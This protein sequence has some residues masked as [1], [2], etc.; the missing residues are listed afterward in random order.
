MIDF[1]LA[2]V[3]DVIVARPMRDNSNI[4]YIFSWPNATD[5]TLYDIFVVQYDQ[6]Q[7]L[8][9]TGLTEQAVIETIEFVANGGWFQ[10]PTFAPS[11]PPAATTVELLASMGTHTVQ[12][13]APFNTYQWGQRGFLWPPHSDPVAAP[14]RSAWFHTV[15]PADDTT[16]LA[17]RNMR[18]ECGQQGILI[19]GPDGRWSNLTGPYYPNEGA[20]FNYGSGTNASTAWNVRTVDGRMQ[21]IPTPDVG[22]SSHGWGSWGRGARA[23]YPGGNLICYG[24]F[25]KVVDTGSGAPV[26]RAGVAIGSDYFMGIDHMW[27]TAGVSK[28]INQIPNGQIGIQKGWGHGRFVEVSTE[29]TPIMMTNRPRPTELPTILPSFPGPIS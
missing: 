4:E 5:A 28:P 11:V 13:P 10:R 22:F 8:V 18:I 23:Q 17:S 6:V 25:R 2:K 29:W 3:N 15:V 1:Y 12:V 7:S 14:I 24:W 19:E 26:G 16:P 27:D 21:Y 20:N 9:A